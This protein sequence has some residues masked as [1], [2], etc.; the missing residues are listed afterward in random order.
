MG[1]G[2]LN[3]AQYLKDKPEL[4]ATI[5]KAVME[6]VL[7]ESKAADLDPEDKPRPVDVA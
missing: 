3:A 4:V 1:V 7:A 2:R 5:R 6:K